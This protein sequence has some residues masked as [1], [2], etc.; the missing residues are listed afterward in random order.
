M[1]NELAVPGNE[2]PAY[3][4]GKEHEIKDDNFDS[5]DIVVPRIKLLQGLS[6]E[7]EKYDH[8]KV[9]DFWHTGASLGIGTEFDFVVVTRK[10]KYLLSTPTIDKQ[11]ILARA[12]DG[13]TWDRE[14]SW[15]VQIDK[16][17][18]VTWEITDKDVEKSGLANW[19]T[20][21]PE[22]ENS[23]PAAT[24]FYDYLVLLPDHP[25]FGVAL[26]TLARSQIKPAKTGLNSK[27]AFHKSN[28]RPV[29]SLL[30]KARATTV[31]NDDNESYRN[32]QFFQNGFNQ[33]E[34]L[35][36]RAVEMS[37]ELTEYKGQDE[38]DAVDESSKAK[39]TSDKF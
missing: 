39:A 5:S 4:K 21:D 16:K 25:E 14:G 18:R 8:A 35:F 10:K 36:N 22:D 1:S 29:Q 19:G 3:L 33:D 31:T 23:Y 24:L 7:I 26:I 11:G 13:R 38:Q 17:T 30:F 27:I 20:W 37:E 6:P 34:D 32:W 28:G 12:D 9:G 2:V 15:E